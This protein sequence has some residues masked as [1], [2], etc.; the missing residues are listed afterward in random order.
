MASLGA[1]CRSTVRTR[2]QREAQNWTALTSIPKSI[3]LETKL[4]QLR[5][6]TKKLVP[7][8]AP[9]RMLEAQPANIISSSKL[10]WPIPVKLSLLLPS[11]TLSP[12]RGKRALDLR[13]HWWPTNFQWRSWPPRKT[14]LQHKHWL[15]SHSN[16][17]V[18]T[19]SKRLECGSGLHQVLT[20]ST[21]PAPTYIAVDLELS[22][23]TLPSVLT[24]HVPTT[25][26]RY[27]IPGGS[28]EVKKIERDLV[29][30]TRTSHSGH[31]QILLDKISRY[32]LR[33]KLLVSSTDAVSGFKIIPLFI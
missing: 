30:Y 10:V 4:L 12:L 20:K 31:I 21:L 5:L 1:L 29:T 15:L 2:I 17:K 22:L 32:F 23:T 13:A 19:T 3:T 27:V 8:K 25:S 18:Q 28:S 7:Q 24:V 9:G 6:S 33:S 16:A 26:A 14:P 11:P